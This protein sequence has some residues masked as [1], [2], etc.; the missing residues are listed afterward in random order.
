MV[1]VKNENGVLTYYDND[2]VIT[3]AEAKALVGATPEGARSVNEKTLLD[4]AGQALTSN[5]EFLDVA[6]PTNAQSLAQI[7]AL[8]RQVNALIRLVTKNLDATD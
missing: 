3:L 5:R 4:R 6:A 7:K 2:I 1:T 8:T